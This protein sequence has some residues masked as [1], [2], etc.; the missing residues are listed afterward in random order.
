MAKVIVKIHHTKSEKGK[1][2]FADYIANRDGVDK[3]V[4]QKMLLGKPTQKQME[5]IKELL[6]ICPGAKDSFEYEDYIENPTRQ[7][8]SA[9]IS[10]IE[11]EIPNTFEGKEQYLNYIA[12][13]PRVEKFGTHG[14]FGS[15][16][17]VKLS[18]VR[19]ELNN[20]KGVMW[21]P[22]IS[23]KREDAQRLG[24]DNAETWKELIRAKQVELAELFK[25]P[26]SEFKWY[27]AFHNE[28]H[29]PHA[30]M[31]VYS[32]D[33]KSGYLTEKN[34]EKIKSTLA[35]EIFKNDM[36]ELYDEKTQARE[37]IAD[38]AKNKL[39]SIVETIQ[40]QDYSE[41]EISSM[42]LS[43]SCALSKVKGK[44]QYG[45]L[46][47][48]LKKAVEDIVKVMATEPDIQ[49]LYDE[50]CGVQ[51]KIVEIYKGSDVEFPPLWENK[52]FKKIRNAVVH[53]AVNLENDSVFFN[54][55][56]TELESDKIE[57]MPKY[58]LEVAE[59]TELK[60]DDV[61]NVEPPTSN[62]KVKSS[63]VEC[64]YRGDYREA[65]KLLYVDKD[66]ETAFYILMREAKV[67][68]A[69]ACFDLGKMYANGWFVEKD[70]Q[71]ANKYFRKA[72]NAYLML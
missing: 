53:E 72:L 41:S 67:N 24:Y 11:E 32:T 70:E 30:H 39:R 3:S 60:E 64:N 55:D 10:V 23:L 29:H 40:G 44:K 42:L 2:K 26:L 43:L 49:K 57:P 63:K 68:N 33:G 65:R 18:E 6:E 36:Y 17:D 71:Q 37:K 50:W 56:N 9:F 16:D 12:T 35:N 13:R 15:E 54:H 52:E 5:Y 21:T 66:F 20:H 31:I 34:I 7:N 19:R 25:I 38:E 28:G 51:K 47:K 8:A 27:G 59:E 61:E 46:P 58:K 48:P 14:L 22:I 69:P 45:Y 1:G 4:N 62:Y